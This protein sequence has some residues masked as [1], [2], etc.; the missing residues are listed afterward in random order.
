MILEEA[1][2]CL[3]NSIILLNYTYTK[4]TGSGSGYVKFVENIEANSNTL[5]NN[6]LYSL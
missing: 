3:P 1:Y 6:A 4:A 2:H 5:V